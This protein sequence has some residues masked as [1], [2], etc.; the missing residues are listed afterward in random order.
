VASRSVVEYLHHA[1]GIR[2]AHTELFSVETKRVTPRLS[3]FSP[4]NPVRR[5]A[6][7]GA[8]RLRRSPPGARISGSDR[9][10]KAGLGLARFV[11]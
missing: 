3:G 7:W 9:A 6:R 2:K 4:D 11:L 1:S 10:E 8:K 5:V